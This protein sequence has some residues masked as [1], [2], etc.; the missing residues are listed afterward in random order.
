MTQ[1]GRWT[2]EEVAPNGSHHPQLIIT[3]F[4]YK[5]LAIYLGDAVPKVLRVSLSDKCL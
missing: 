5:L 4:I 1:T 2:L 3:S